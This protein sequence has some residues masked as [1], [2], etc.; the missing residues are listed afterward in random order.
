MKAIDKLKPGLKGEK[1]IVV[2]KEHTAPHVGSGVVPVLATP[3]MVN[4]LEAAA[5]AA[6]EKYLPAGY[7]T[8]GTVLNVKHFAAT[9]VGLEVRAFAKLIRVEGRTLAFALEAEDEIEAI[10]RGSHER[11]VVNV[12]RFE[13]RVKKKSETAR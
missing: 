3:V 5:L 4:L 7:Q 10:G 11:V 8:L 1:S 6:V 2:A 13:Q 9:P 12:D